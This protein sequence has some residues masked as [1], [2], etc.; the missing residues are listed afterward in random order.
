MVGGGAE[1]MKK[2][3][4]LADK[5]RKILLVPL[6]PVHDIGLKVIR[7]ALNAAGHQTMLLPPDRTLEEVIRAVSEYRPE[8]TLV[9]RTVGYGTAEVLGRLADMMEAA[10]LRPATQLVIGGMAVR[11]GLAAELG[12]DASFG[13]GT[14]PEMVL[15]YIDGQSSP[16][17]VSAGGGAAGGAAPKRRDLVAGY[18]YD[19]RN[20]RIGELAHHIASETLSWA[21]T[22]TSPGVER[23]E[24][25]QAMLE[26]PSG[27]GRYREAY[28]KLC[29]DLIR[30]A[31]EEKRAPEHTRFLNS[32]E[33]AFLTAGTGAAAAPGAPPYT[34]PVRPPLARKDGKPTVFVQYGTGCPLMDAA[35]IRAVRNWGA[36]GVI[37]FDPSWAAR[38]EGLASGLL[39]HEHDGTVMTLENLR[40]LRQAV[41]PDLLWQ[42]RAH[43]G[44]NTPETVVLAAA[45][46]A[47]LTKINVAYGSLGAGTEPA[48]LTVDAVKA[49]AL[50]A[51]YGLPFDVVTNEE[52]SGVPAHKAMAGMLITVAMGIGL[53]GHPIL[54]PLFCY[55]PEVMLGGQMADN[56]IDFN[57]AKVIAL[58]Q[59]LDAPIWPGAPVGFLTQTEDRVQ[60]SV[61]TALHAALAACLGVEAVTI[62]S[63]DEAY[64]GGAITVAARLDTL[65][66]AAEAFRFLGQAHIQPTL[67]AA[68]WAS[69][70]VEGVEMVLEQVARVGVLPEAIY[71]GLLGSPDDGVYPGRAG[72]GTV[73]SR[74]AAAALPLVPKGP[75]GAR[76]R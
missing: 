10:G 55:S 37:H 21:A 20:D 5:P 6:D 68:R 62:A 42:V 51:R 75:G 3:P 8:F 28:L 1:E 45:A 9:G 66:A 31:E 41:G 72:R 58:R 13:P 46:G 48:R 23:A 65:T 54:Q 50:A 34:P 57:A 47:D 22:R 36:G 43:R 12:F 38:T 29:D 33:E 39:S 14:S 11:D 64:S 76:S 16:K 7:R 70:M 52:L 61:S 35:H 26:D 56:Y 15:A 4:F 30:Q 2:A 59:I 49:I 69:E 24:L 25:R 63:A 17:A 40:A 32:E 27:I 44:L 19:F 73:R 60:S 53:G 18:S 67:A 74:E 71:A